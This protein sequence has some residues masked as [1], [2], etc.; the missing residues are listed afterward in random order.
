MNITAVVSL[1]IAL[2]GLLVQLNLCIS[3]FIVILAPL[4][5][6]LTTYVNLVLTACIAI[7]GL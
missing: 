2:Q 6:S 3:G 4:C 7:L 5:V 1:D